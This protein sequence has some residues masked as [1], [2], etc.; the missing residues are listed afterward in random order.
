MS[1]FIV[2]KKKTL[3][4]NFLLLS[5]LVALFIYIIFNMDSLATFKESIINGNKESSIDLDGDG[6]LDT[7]TIENKKNTYIIKINCKNKSYTLTSNCSNNELG[8]NIK[9]CPLS[10]KY[11][12]LSRSN[13]PSILVT[14]YKNG[15]PI[16]HLFTWIDNSFCDIFCSTN[17]LTGILDSDNSKSPTFVS[18]SSKKGDSSTSLFMMENNK[19]RDISFSKQTVP[20]IKN[21]QHFIDTVQLP[22]ELDESPDIFTE[23]IDS[24]ELSILWNLNKE[25]FSYS[26]QHG[27]FKDTKWDS[28]SNIY[29]ISWILSF[30]KKPKVSGD[31]NAEEL[32]LHLIFTRTEDDSFKISSIKKI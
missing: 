15:E 27:F 19:L 26:F 24:N 2:I 6:N 22:Y 20:S 3:I 14:G 11:I 25:S 10:V 1:K 31:T 32:K 30:E 21:L 18:L 28:N 8:D 29:E 23:D 9:S 7:L 12:Y 4:N 13:T 16:H 17:N 5:F